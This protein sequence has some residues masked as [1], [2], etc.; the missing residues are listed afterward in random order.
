MPNESTRASESIINLIYPMVM[1]LEKLIPNLSKST[2][3]SNVFNAIALYSPSSYP[4][5][6]PP[7]SPVAHGGNHGRCSWGEPRRSMCG[8]RFR[9]RASPRPRWFTATRLRVLVSFVVRLFKTFTAK[10]KTDNGA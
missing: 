9:T 5:G 6:S 10:P 1:S 4:A 2:Q 7:G 3:V 8:R